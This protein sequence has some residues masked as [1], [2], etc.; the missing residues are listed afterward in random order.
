MTRGELPAVLNAEL[1]SLFAAV[2]AIEAEAREVRRNADEVT[3]R[4]RRVFYAL[5]LAAVLFTS[6][7]IGVALCVVA[8][9]V[10]AASFA[11]WHREERRAQSIDARVRSLWPRVMPLCIALDHVAPRTRK[12][13]PEA[14]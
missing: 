14:S 6:Q 7:R 5:N 11:W 3:K 10:H 13:I 4:H 8:L 2:D 12:P 9:A 1:R